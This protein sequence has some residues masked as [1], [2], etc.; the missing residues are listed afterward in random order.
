MVA[1]VD[2][3]SAS[4]FRELAHL[5]VAVIPASIK[6]A[7]CHQDHVNDGIRL[8]RDLNGFVQACVAALVLAVGKQDHGL[9]ADF[10]RQDLARSKIYGVVQ[11]SPLRSTDA[12]Y[13]TLSDAGNRWPA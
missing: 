4:L 11:Q 5:A 9:A 2:H 12:R 10:V 3:A 7:V 6:A 8:L 13:G 1:D